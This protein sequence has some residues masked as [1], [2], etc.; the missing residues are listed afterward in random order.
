MS[1]PSA[2]VKSY[3][4]SPITTI[5]PEGP[6]RLG[7]IV[8][9][10]SFVQEPINNPPVP[11]GSAG[12]N[13]YLHN[14]AQSTVALKASKSFALGLFVKF[15]QFLQ[16]K[17]GEKNSSAVEEMWSFNNLQTQWFIPSDE[18]IK[19]SLQQMEVQNFIAQNYSWLRRTKLYMVTGIMIA[20]GASST[21]KAAEQNELHLSLG[22][23]T[24]LPQV[25]VTVLPQLGLEGASG[26]AKSQG[27]SDTVVFA[28]QLRRIK[29][30]PAGDVAHAQYTDG[31][32]LSVHKDTGSDKR[33]YQIVMDGIDDSD[34]DPAEFGL[35]GSSLDVDDATE[36]RS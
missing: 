2:R 20:E 11:P 17:I 25:P 26:V 28:F 24:P 18:Y 16:G 15:Q 32:L 9:D 23:D 34:V 19:Q 31:A 3:F 33:S 27:K 12:E 13:I 1:L 6:I 22:V 8:E 10:P 29:I 21:I 35:E 36:E 4:L 7:S 14:A 30:S 5:P